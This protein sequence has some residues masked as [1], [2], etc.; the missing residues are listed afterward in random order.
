VYGTVCRLQQ[1]VDR[2]ARQNREDSPEQ[3][4]VGLQSLQQGLQSIRLVGQLDQVPA[5]FLFDCASVGE[6]Y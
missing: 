4:V 6:I 5:G 1:L 2:A 3:L